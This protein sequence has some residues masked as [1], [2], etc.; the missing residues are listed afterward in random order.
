MGILH[1][2]TCNDWSDVIE[3]C[4]R[5]VSKDGKSGAAE[6]HLG[7]DRVDH[8]GRAPLHHAAKL[9]NLAAC[10]TLLGAGA[11]ATL[12]DRGGRTPAHVA[13]D[14]G[15]KD[16]LMLLIDSGRVDATQR[17]FEDRD[18]ARWAA[19]LDCVDVMMAVEGLPGARLGRADR[20]GK[21]PIDIAYICKCRNVGLF[22]ASRQ[23]HLDAYR[24]DSLYVRPAVQEEENHEDGIAS[25]LRSLD[26]S[27]TS[28]AEREQ[29]KQMESKY[30]AEDWSLVWCGNSDDADKR[31][32]RY[33]EERAKAVGRR[34]GG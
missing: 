3:M 17:D 30:R 24:W 34:G 10:R 21:R 13:A 1:H 15:F 20:H 29:R 28:E 22:L 23:L 12:K 5:H 7:P 18:L 11:S 32:E 27:G 26:V 31:M 19:T 25:K 4:L 2:A 33:R 8:S 9:G 16:V 6:A 14:A